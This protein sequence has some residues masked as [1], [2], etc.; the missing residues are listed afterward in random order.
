MNLTNTENYKIE[1]NSFP[2]K[3][4]ITTFIILTF[5]FSFIIEY[6]IIKN[7]SSVSNTQTNMY[8]ILLMWTP[9]FGAIITKLIFFIKKSETIFT[10]LFDPSS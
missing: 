9:A 2:T 10:N 6:L 4:P 3:L 7:I 1:K 8:L 5:L